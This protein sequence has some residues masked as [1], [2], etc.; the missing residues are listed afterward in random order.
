MTDT[1]LRSGRMLAYGCASSVAAAGIV[2]SALRSRSNSYSAAVM[3]GRSNGGMMVLLNFGV[4]LTLS[5]AR[6]MQKIFFGQLRAVETEHLYERMWYAITES[7]LATTIFRSEFDASFVLLFG[8]LLIM[9][10]FH[11]LTADRVE[12]MEQSPSLTAIFHLRMICV[13]GMLLMIDLLLVALTVEVLLENRRVGMMIMFTSEF[14]ILLVNMLSTIGKYT[15]NC[16]DAR[17]EEPWEG[18]SMYF[19]GIDLITDFLKLA[20]YLTFFAMILTYYG[21]P[22]NI[23]RDVYLTGRSLFSKIRDLIRYRAATKNMDGRYPSATA[24]DMQVMSDGTCIICREEMVIAGDPDAPSS[25]YSNGLNHTPK[26]L[27]CGHIFHFHCLR[28]WLERQQS[29]PTCRRT[30]FNDPAVQSTTTPALAA[31]QG[32]GEANADPSAAAAPAA[33]PQLPQMPHTSTNAV[34]PPAAT[35]GHRAAPPAPAQVLSG[36]EPTPWLTASTAAPAESAHRR[37]NAEGITSDAPTSHSE[38]ASRDWRAYSSGWPA[39]ASASGAEADARLRA[40]M[41][42]HTFNSAL[43]GASSTSNSTATRGVAL[44]DPASLRAAVPP[45]TRVPV[46]QGGQFSWSSSPVVPSAAAVE[47]GNGPS[48][49]Q[50]DGPVQRETQEEHEEADDESC[51]AAVSQDEMRRSREARLKRFQAEEGQHL[52][53]NST[54]ASVSP[55]TGERETRPGSG[56]GSGGGVTLTPILQVSQPSLQRTASL[57]DYM[58]SLAVDGDELSREQLENLSRL[59]RR[60]IEERLRVLHRIDQQIWNS[61]EDLTRCLSILPADDEVQPSSP[62]VT[63]GKGKEHAE[64]SKSL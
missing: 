61:V 62:E 21:L 19:F 6:V 26:K 30:V 60:G 18:K 46:I 44:R 29:C 8:T 25:T 1:F 53:E 16:I 7:L 48:S 11:W 31:A 5:F 37:A 50:S 32:T 64:D 59:T 15:I 17:S 10:A 41:R 28:A 34:A 42:N 56:Y 14:S 38:Q 2:L 54:T 13:Q 9:K 20:I 12:Y 52:P 22:L 63:D 47:E 35:P 3:V 58:D 57:Q 45:P 40:F 33:P 23:V 43:S 49:N 55:Q 51:G 27:P 4:F 36:T 24:V 39:S